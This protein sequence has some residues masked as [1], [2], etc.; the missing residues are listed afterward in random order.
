M[1]FIN[2]IHSVVEHVVPS[3]YTGIAVFS[4]YSALDGDYSVAT[5][6]D[7]PQYPNWTPKGL[8]LFRNF[9]AKTELSTTGLPAGDPSFN[10][11]Y[12]LPDTTANPEFP[13]SY[14]ANT[15]QG[16]QPPQVERRRYFIIAPGYEIDTN[17]LYLYSDSGGGR[18]DNVCSSGYR[19]EEFTPSN[20]EGYFGKFY[21]VICTGNLGKFAIKVLPSSSNS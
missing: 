8:G 4:Q 7:N 19:I 14:L 3:F 9:L 10:D 21:C 6:I 1:P 12:T 5:I 18:W 16:A 11:W 17:I 2:P 15:T 13:Q 20:P